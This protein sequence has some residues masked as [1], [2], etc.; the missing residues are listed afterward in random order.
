MYTLEQLKIFV[1]VTELGSFS[2]V[3]RKLNRAQSGI[4]QAI[5]NLE[6]EFNQELFVR[7]K[8]SVTLTENGK[9]L[10]PQIK[11]LLQQ[12]QFL[13][14]KLTA[15]EQTQEHQITIAFDETLLSDDLTDLFQQVAEQFPTTIIELITA[16]TFDI[17]TMIDSGQAHLGV[18]YRNYTSQNQLDMFFLGYNRF[19][20]VAA[21]EHPLA[22][23]DIVSLDDL[24]R[25][26]HLVH[27]SLE[28]KEHLFSNAL[29]PM[30]WYSNSYYNLLNL[31]EGN[32]GWADVPERLAENALKQGR[33]V[34]LKLEAEP[35]GNV[36]PVIC[37]RSRQLSQGKVMT[38]LV[39]MLEQHWE[40]NK[41]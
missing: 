4:S 13:D 38:Y 22:K 12:S 9:A 23:S 16:S 15:L 5:G 29:S 6:I 27:R 33:L 8:G 21:P 14:Q 26:R 18:A 31:A 32:I 37:L 7:E 10:L 36:I 1:A 19:I 25:H 20:A 39:K 11:L 28:H 24:T 2:A 41:K 35:E 30:P 17:E 3:A 40:R 34:K